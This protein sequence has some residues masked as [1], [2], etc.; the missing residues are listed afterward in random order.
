MLSILGAGDRG[1]ELTGLRQQN[2]DLLQSFRQLKRQY[3]ELLDVNI[4]DQGDQAALQEKMSLLEGELQACKDD[5][6]RLQPVSQTSDSEIVQQYESL[7]TSICEWVEDEVS[8]CMDNWQKL[9]DDES[10]PLLFHHNRDSYAKK[11]LATYPDT[12]GEYI[13]RYRLQHMLH[14]LF[15]NEAIFLFGL[16]PGDALLLQTIEEG[17]ET[18]QPERGK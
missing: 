12:A 1:R 13:I 8:R 16:H 5:L 2:D 9:D 11:L 14:Y 18:L 17:M 10:S 6:F 4:Q 15:Y 7:N 3:E